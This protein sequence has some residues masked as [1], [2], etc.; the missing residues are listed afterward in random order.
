MKLERFKY[1]RYLLNIM[2]W[3][4]FLLITLVLMGCV[5]QNADS[6]EI[7]EID[8]IKDVEEIDEAE[9]IIEVEK[10]A[11]IKPVKVQEPEVKVPMEKVQEKEMAEEVGPA[12]VESV[13]FDLSRE[14]KEMID[15]GKQ[16]ENYVYDFTSRVKNKFDG[17]H[18]EGFKVSY[19]DGKVK[20][21]LGGPIKLTIKDYITHVYV[22]YKAGTAIGVCR[23]ST[24]RCDQ[25]VNNGYKLEFRAEKLEVVPSDF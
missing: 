23:G 6:G 22:D 7:E 11:E 14:I 24:F 15:R 17:Y 16:K 21:D 13:I 9:T 10:T 19:K 2:K 3:V 1:A 4:T 8:K 5:K 20:K 12:D 25:I 18:L